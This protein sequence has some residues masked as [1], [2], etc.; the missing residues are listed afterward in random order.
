MLKY[1]FPNQTC[2]VEHDGVKTAITGYRGDYIT[3]RLK[4]GRFYEIEMLT[5]LQKVIPQGSTIIDAG[6][7]IG[8]HSLFFAKHCKA[9]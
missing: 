5:H 3:K 6:A 4:L 8:N 7:F 2:V 1:L 9:T